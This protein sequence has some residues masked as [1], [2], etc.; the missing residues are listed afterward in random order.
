[1]II[2]YAEQ[3]GKEAARKVHKQ[4][5]KLVKGPEAIKR[6]LAAAGNDSTEGK[7]FPYPKGTKI[8]SIIKEIIKCED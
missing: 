4:V 7:T 5:G 3:L 8:G 2:K 6:E 1:M